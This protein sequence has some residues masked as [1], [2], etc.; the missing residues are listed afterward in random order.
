MSD[1]E[2][3]KDQTPAEKAYR[4]QQLQKAEMALEEMLNTGRISKRIYYKGQIIIARDYLIDHKQV[5]RA[6]DIVRRCSPQYFLTDQKDDMA[7]DPK[8]EMVV[9]ELAQRLVDLELID[10]TP[11]PRFT[12]SLAKA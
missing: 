7:A 8:Y 9:M 1:E 11:M 2:Q 4:L 6:A 5:V 12:Q 3:K 10:A